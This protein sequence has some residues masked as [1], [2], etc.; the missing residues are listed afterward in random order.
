[1]N[2]TQNLTTINRTVYSSRNIEYI[3]VH[4]FGAL[5]SAKST[6]AYFKNVNRKASAHYFVDDYGIWQCVE[7]KNASWHCGDSGI[8]T[9]KGLCK[10]ANSIGIETRPYKISTATMSAADTDWYFHEQTTDNLVEL[11][12]SLMVTH[13][14]DIDHVIRHYD[15]TEK[16]CPRPWLG[17]DVNAYYG[18]TGNQLW[19]EFK[20]RL[21]ESEG[22]I[23]TGEEIYNALK[24][25][26]NTAEAPE[27]ARLELAEAVEL[28]ITDGTRPMELI[29]RY[30]AAIMAKRAAKK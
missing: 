15:V 27:W 22:D 1:M 16:W 28:G 9:F 4:Y 30:Q 14:I 19:A 23:M 10:N 29:P 7:D 25:Y 21:T 20:T 12:K 8:G 13:N 17:D 2:I 11:V 6:C 18:K 24:E 5:G 3:V 26:T